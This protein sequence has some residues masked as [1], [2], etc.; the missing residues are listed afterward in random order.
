MK[1]FTLGLLND[2]TRHI[3]AAQIGIGAV[4]HGADFGKPVPIMESRV[5]RFASSRSLK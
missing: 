3:L 4:A 1:V 5:T 2:G